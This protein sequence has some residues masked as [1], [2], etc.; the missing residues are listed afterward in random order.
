MGV[1]KTMTCVVYGGDEKSNMAVFE[2]NMPS[3]YVI[4]QDFISAANLGPLYKRHDVEEGG[5]KAAIYFDHFSLHEKCFEIVALKEFQVSNPS[6]ADALVYDY[7][8]TTKMAEA[9]YVIE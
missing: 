1:L 7:Y 2:L 6:P 9:F 3:G 5:A 4:D 8:D